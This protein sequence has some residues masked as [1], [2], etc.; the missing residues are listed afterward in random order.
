MNSNDRFCAEFLT[1]Y[2]IL[3]LRAATSGI[4][5][6]GRSSLT[7]SQDENQHQSRPLPSTLQSSQVFSNE[8]VSITNW[9]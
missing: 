5:P 7:S 3:I 9:H 4:T 1:N 6:A 8:Y 2:A